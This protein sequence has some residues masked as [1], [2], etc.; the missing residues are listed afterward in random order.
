MRILIT[1]VTEMHAGNYCVAGWCTQLNEMVRPLPNGANWT[2]RLLTMHTVVP[3]STVG[4]QPIRIPLGSVYPHRTE[5]TPIDQS[6]I[7]LFRRG[8]EPWF[9]P[10]AP[11]TALT[12][13]EAFQ[14]QVG[15]NSVW[16]GCMQGVY[17][18]AGATVRSLWAIRVSRD[19]LRFEVDFEKLKAVLDDGA[20]RYRLAV[21]SAALKEAWRAGGLAEIHQALPHAGT[22]H[23]RVGL[24][25]AWQGQPDKCYAMIN[26]VYW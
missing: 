10:G 17:V 15:H 11:P 12:L 14:G 2:S 1:D 26:G 24:A 18:P 19:R 4:V 3:G 13:D 25:R 23:V 8:P 16:N 7:Q 9:G 5:D 6:S 22:L 21:S 20:N